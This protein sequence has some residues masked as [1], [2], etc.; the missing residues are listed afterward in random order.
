MELW[1]L[2]SR[3]KK[4]RDKALHLTAKSYAP[5]GALLLAAGERGR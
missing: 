5:I 4:R 2:A 1:L 3:S